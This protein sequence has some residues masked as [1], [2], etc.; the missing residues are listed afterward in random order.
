MV[1]CGC[2]MRRCS[3]AVKYVATGSVTQC[4]GEGFFLAR[5]VKPAVGIRAHCAMRQCILQVDAVHGDCRIPVG[6]GHT[7]AVQC[8]LTGDGKAMQAAN[9]SSAHACWLCSEPRALWQ[10]QLQ[11]VRD[12]SAA[13][14]YGAFLRGIPFSPVLGILEDSVEEGL[15]GR[16]LVGLVGQGGDMGKLMREMEEGMKTLQK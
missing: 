15:S 4:I 8:L 14:R 1:R 5:V 9:Y 13:V 3:S 16:I 10:G 12:L 6:G 7:C 11:P 2:W